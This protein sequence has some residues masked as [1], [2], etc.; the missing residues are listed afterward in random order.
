MSWF[1]LHNQTLSWSFLSS[2]SGQNLGGSSPRPLSAEENPT[3]IGKIDVPASRRSFSLLYIVC[4]DHLGSIFQNS[5]FYDPN[6]T[7]EQGVCCVS[8]A[9][10]L[11]AG[12]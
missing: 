6:P 1:S 5:L 11:V 8:P 9:G 10:S 12:G 2:D 3:E 7:A 4:T